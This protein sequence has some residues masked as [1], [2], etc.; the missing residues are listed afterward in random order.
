MF[1]TSI[2]AAG[3]HASGTALLQDD[4]TADPPLAEWLGAAVDLAD[5]EARTAEARRLAALEGPTLEDWLA[6]AA[7][8]QP[9]DGGAAKPGRREFEVELWVSGE[10]ERTT[11]TV[12]VPESYDPG[13]PAPLLVALRGAGGDG[14]S[15]VWPWAETAEELGAVLLAPTEVGPNVGFQAN[16]RERES[17]VAAVR[18]AR[19]HYPID[20]NRVWLTGY[21]RGAHLCWDL[22]LRHPDVFAAAVPCAGAPRF[23]LAG[24]AA[25]LR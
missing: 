8:L 6:A 19:R 2:L 13:V 20:E 18:W 10:V 17:V 4:V 24:G 1:V 5:P 16:V 7:E 14:P 21:S 25:N 9:I 23:A 22:V 11:L 3:L 12:V 15:M